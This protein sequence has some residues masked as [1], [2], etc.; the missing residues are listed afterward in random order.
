MRHQAGFEEGGGP[1]LGAVDELVHHHK[2]TRRHGGIQ[3]AN[4]RHSQHIGATQALQRIDIGADVQL[5]GRDAVA[6][7]VARQETHVD[8]GNAAGQDRIRWFAPR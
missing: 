3:R 2:I 5:V 8:A 6:A 1:S 7:A 4:R